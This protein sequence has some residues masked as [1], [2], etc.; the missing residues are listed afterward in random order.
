MTKVRLETNAPGDF[1]VD[2]SCIDCDTCRW[3]APAT[4]DRARGQSRVHVQP[5]DAAE[6]HRALQALVACPTSSIHATERHDVRAVL[7]SFPDPVDGNVYACG[8]HS[9]KS[10]GATSYLIVRD[11][12]RGNVLVDSPRFAAPLVERIEELGGVA[13]MF[14]THRDDVADHARYR[15][16]F[17]CRRVLHEAD[18]EPDTEAVEVVL[19]GDRAS[20]LDD[21]LEAIPTPGHTA[22]ST[23][24]RYGERYLFT[25]D[26]LA[27]NP[28]TGGI[29]AFR[30]ACWFDWSTQIESVERLIDVPFE[31][32]LPGH[33]H[34]GRFEP[35][36]AREALVECVREMRRPRAGT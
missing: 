8:F 11:G 36:A 10:F 14:L 21:D 15:E 33:G 24:L 19:R 6:V 9:E 17:G 23:C 31:W 25:G 34:R 3:M 32:L 5:R 2:S 13:W 20:R 1:F 28:R 35:S 4:F 7:R 30:S 22:G 27:R 18:L 16:R 26:H 12:G 29:Y